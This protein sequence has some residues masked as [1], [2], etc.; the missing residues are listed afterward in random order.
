MFLSPPRPSSPS[1]EAASEW[2][3]SNNPFTLNKPTLFVYCMDEPYGSPRQAFPP[4]SHSSHTS[5]LP[6]TSKV[7][8]YRPCLLMT[9]VGAVVGHPVMHT[10]RQV[11]QNDSEGKLKK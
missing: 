1:S 5:L 2:R 3:V 8:G 7:V 9:G 4:P 11:A 10:M 6:P